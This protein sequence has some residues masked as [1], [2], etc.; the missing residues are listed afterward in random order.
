MLCVL[1]ACTLYQTY[2]WSNNRLI[3][4]HEC[5]HAIAVAARTTV[6]KSRFAITLSKRVCL[7]DRG[8]TGGGLVHEDD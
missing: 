3:G 5:P 2:I 7:I 6:Q 1:P 8:R 4:L